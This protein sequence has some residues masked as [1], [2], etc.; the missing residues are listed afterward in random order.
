VS[1]LIAEVELGD[2]RVFIVR[3]NNEIDIEVHPNIPHL[4]EGN[5]EVIG[6]STINL[7]KG[8]T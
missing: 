3:D 4:E 6:W 2:I 8:G 1:K 7:Q 5:E